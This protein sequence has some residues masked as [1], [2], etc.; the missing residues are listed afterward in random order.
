MI[1]LTPPAVAR[2]YKVDPD[3]VRGWLSS[4]ELRGLNVA[5]RN[6][7]RPRWRISPEAL[8]EF[9]RLR[10]AVPKIEPKRT[11]RKQ[12]TGKEWF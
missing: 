6:C 8:Q 1:Y 4:G 11:K 9:E 3:T 2:I 5:R 12:V 7:R 10:A